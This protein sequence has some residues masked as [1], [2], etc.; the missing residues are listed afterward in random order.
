VPRRPRLWFLNDAPPGV[1]EDRQHF[2][3]AV[4]QEAPIVLEQLRQRVW[5]HWKAAADDPALSPFLRALRENLIAA[6]LPPQLEALRIGL[7]DWSVEFGLEATWLTA[8]ALETLHD[9]AIDPAHPRD[10]YWAVPATLGD[11]FESGASW[12]GGRPVEAPRRFRSDHFRW[13]A[14]WQALDESG[15]MIALKQIERNKNLDSARTRV[16]KLR[17]EAPG[18]ERYREV[19]DALTELARAEQAERLRGRAKVKGLERQG[20]ERAVKVLARHLGLPLRKHK[21]G[22]KPRAT[23]R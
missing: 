6:A 22:R 15:D 11:G 2:L 16:L 21:R 1:W 14:C 7:R 4:R 9:W 13:L 8:A 20:I 19:L 10:L 23:G 3:E 12:R 17:H 5:P 18:Q